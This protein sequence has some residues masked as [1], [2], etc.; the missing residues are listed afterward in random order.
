MISAREFKSPYYNLKNLLDRKGLTQE[1]VADK[2]NMPR[3]TFN[4]KINRKNGRDFS[5]EEAK[6]ISKVIN[7]TVDNFF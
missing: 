5:L 7:E 1:V 4:L 2:I 3:S 6:Q